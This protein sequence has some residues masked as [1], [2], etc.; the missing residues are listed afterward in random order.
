MGFV[1]P[2]CRWYHQSWSTSI[3]D[4]LC[5]PNHVNHTSDFAMCVNMGGALG[6]LSWLDAKTPPIVSIQCPYDPFAPYDDAVLNVPIPGGQLP[7]V[8]VQ[9]SLAVQRKWMNWV[10]TILFNSIYGYERSNRSAI[11]VKQVD[12]SICSQ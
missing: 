11:S 8:R 6:D 9:G 4:T 7:V 3:R 12:M 5:F 1:P 10:S 2:K